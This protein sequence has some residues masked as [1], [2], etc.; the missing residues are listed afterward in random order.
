MKLPLKG[1]KVRP[2][3][4]FINGVWMKR[5]DVV[6]VHIGGL[7]LLTIPKK[8]Y[9]VPNE[10]YRTLEGQVQPTFYECEYKLKNWKLLLS[11]GPILREKEQK[12]R[13]LIA[14]ERS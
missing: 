12:I 1:F 14:Y 8:M 3:A 13:D 6:S 2:V 9:S 11:R 5:P 7:H 4:A 10:R